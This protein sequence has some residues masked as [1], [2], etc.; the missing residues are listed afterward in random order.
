MVIKQVLEVDGNT[1][2]E[3]NIKNFKKVTEGGRT[4]Y[5]PAKVE[6]RALLKEQ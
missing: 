3:G 6:H 5:N 4:T 1:T 2:K